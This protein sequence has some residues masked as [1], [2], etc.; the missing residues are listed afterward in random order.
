[1][2]PDLSCSMSFDAGD[3]RLRAVRQPA[4]DWDTQDI[5]VVF[6]SASDNNEN[7][8][9]LCYEAGGDD[10]IQK[11][12]FDP[13]ELLSKLAAGR[14]HPGREEGLLREQ[15]GY[16]QRTAMAAMVSMG[17]LGVVLQSS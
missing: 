6:I 14:A 4:D 15:A 5:P 8:R 16:A 10:F 9:M 17:E 3:G 12:G 7:A 2:K 11:P 13:A 1:M